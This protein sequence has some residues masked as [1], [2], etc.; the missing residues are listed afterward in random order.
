[1][2]SARCSFPSPVGDETP[3][4]VF[5][6][7]ADKPWAYRHLPPGFRVHSRDALISGVV[8]GHIDPTARPLFVV[9]GGGGRGRA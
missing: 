7:D 3:D 8:K 6:V 4:L 2:R 1:V 9:A 5:G